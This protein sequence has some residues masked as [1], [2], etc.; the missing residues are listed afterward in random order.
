MTQPVEARV[1][2]AAAILHCA[3]IDA[4]LAGLRVQWPAAPAGLQNIAISATA[5]A[6]ETRAEADPVPAANPVAE[7]GPIAAAV[8]AAKRRRPWRASTDKENQ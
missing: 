7:D 6:A 2:A 8:A 5:K 1:R 3:I 4:R